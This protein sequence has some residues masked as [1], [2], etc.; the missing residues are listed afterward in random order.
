MNNLNIINQYRDK[1]FIYNILSL[2]TAT[3]YNRI[4]QIIQLPIILISSIMAILN[5]S[6]KPDD[7][8]IANVVLNGCTALLMNISGTYQIAEKASRYKNT[9]QKWSQL[10]HLIEDK[11]NNHNLENDDIRDIVRVYD[12]L[13]TQCDDIPQFICDKVKKQFE[14]KHLPVILQDSNS[15][16]ARSRPASNSDNA[17]IICDI[18]NMQDTQL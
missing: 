5:S 12:E 17:V 7:M 15:S 18:G 9:G 3:F 2:R 10:L 1:A 13:I 8:Q 4:K 6:F 16:P 11:I 14:G